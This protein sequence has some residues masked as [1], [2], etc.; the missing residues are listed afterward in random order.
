[1]Q[2]TNFVRVMVRVAPGE[3]YQGTG[4]FIT[5]EH[6][7]TSAHLLAGTEAVRVHGRTAENT[8]NASWDAECVWTGG[9]GM[10]AAVLKVSGRGGAIPIVPLAEGPSTRMEPWESRGCP[11]GSG[12]ENDHEL[13]SMLALS[14]KAHRF[15]TDARTFQ[16]EL[17]TAASKVENWQGIS[18]APVFVRDRLIGVIAKTSK[19]FPETLQAVPVTALLSIPGFCV[20]IGFDDRARARERLLEDVRQ[21]LERD[22]PTVDLLVAQHDSWREANQ[23]GVDRLSEAMCSETPVV[24]FLRH[25]NAAHRDGYREGAS[26]KTLKTLEELTGKAVPILTTQRILG[27]VYDEGAFLRL[28]VATETMAELIMAGLH[29]REFRFHGTREERRVPEAEARLCTSVECGIDPGSKVQFRE[30]VEYLAQRFLFDR[31]LGSLLGADGMLG[32][33]RV[34]EAADRVN[35][36]LEWLATEYDLPL[37]HY[38]LFTKRFADTKPGFIRQIEEHLP[39]LALVRLDGTDDR[40]EE[41]RNRPLYDLLRRTE[42]RKQR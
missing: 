10:D 34:E 35:E 29:E 23:D 15:A 11:V 32:A 8:E 12:L 33:D 24:D 6:V 19:I 42:E 31:P 5:R 26:T 3:H 36:E 4:Y 41:F 40:S 30:L 9:K 38:Y 21:L 28:P 13:E 18:G 39:A 2:L 37:R 14:G 25:V 27:L 20:A 22:T 17:S 1:M 7:L 16:L